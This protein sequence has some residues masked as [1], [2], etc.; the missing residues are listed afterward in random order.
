[1]SPSTVLRSVVCRCNNAAY[2]LICDIVH[3]MQRGGGQKYVLVHIYQPNFQRRSL[4][5]SFHLIRILQPSSKLL[6]RHRSVED[7]C[8]IRSHSARRWGRACCQASSSSHWFSI[9][10]RNN[11]CLKYHCILQPVIVG[12]SSPGDLRDDHNLINRTRFKSHK[13]RDETVTGF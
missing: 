12:F 11:H 8:T 2:Q 7:G 13:S 9:G 3:Q 6:Q 4:N 5:G 10:L 1:M